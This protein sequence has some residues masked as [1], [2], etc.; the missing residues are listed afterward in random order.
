MNYKNIVKVYNDN[1]FFDANRKELVTIDNYGNKHT[2][3]NYRQALDDMCSHIFK[4]NYKYFN[5][6]VKN[7]N[8]NNA[9]Y[10]IYTDHKIPTG[11]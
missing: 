6:F 4:Y 1:I 7:G 9:Y 8:D 5:Y 11:Y 10:T 2:F 3:A